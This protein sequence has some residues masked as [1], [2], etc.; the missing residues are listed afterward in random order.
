[1][2]E[3]AA[4]VLDDEFEHDRLEPAVEILAC[5]GESMK[6]IAGQIARDAQDEMI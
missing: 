1:M 4:A 6:V 3:A 2:E 5:R